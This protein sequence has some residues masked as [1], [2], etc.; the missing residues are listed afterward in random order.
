MEYMASQMDSLIEGGIN[1]MDNLFDDYEQK[2][3]SNKN[4]GNQD[5][6]DALTSAWQDIHSPKCGNGISPL[7][8][9]RKLIDNA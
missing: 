7:E 9:M 1:Q 3:K 6:N 2:L 8:Y 4:L 5:I